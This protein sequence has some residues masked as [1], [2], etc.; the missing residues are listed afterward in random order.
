MKTTKDNS[1]RIKVIPPINGS[2]KIR[3]I[4]SAKIL[5]IIKIKSIK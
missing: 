1:V 5:T 3:I 2:T 4:A